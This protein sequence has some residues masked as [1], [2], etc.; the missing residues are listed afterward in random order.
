MLP[1][2]SSKGDHDP[3][4]DERAPLNPSARSSA[5][6]GFGEVDTVAPGLLHCRVAGYVRLEHVEPIIFAANEEI[7]KG[8][9]PLLFIDGD[10]THGYES[11]VRKVFQTWAKR[12]RTTIEAIVVLFRSPL[13]KMGLNLAQGF[14]G[15]VIRGCASTEEFDR[16]LS[17][18]TTRAR[19]G[20]LRQVTPTS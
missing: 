20:G 14:T 6:M 13:V 16:M 12:N 17:E 18:A 5:R 1:M 7:H 15:G 19:A 2:A 9:R 8:Y 4:D 10:D 11:E 3:Q